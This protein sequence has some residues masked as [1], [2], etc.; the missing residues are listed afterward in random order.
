MIHVDMELVRLEVDPKQFW[1]DLET[2][3]MTNVFVRVDGSE[4]T[5]EG[6]LDCIREWYFK[7]FD[8]AAGDLNDWDTWYQWLFQNFTSMVKE[9]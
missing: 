9:E 8:P 2:Y 3:G 4:A 7:C 6:E 5:F 1:E